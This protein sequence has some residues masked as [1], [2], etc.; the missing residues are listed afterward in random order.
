[1][2]HFVQKCN[3]LMRQDRVMDVQEHF[4]LLK[5]GMLKTIYVH[6]MPTVHITLQKSTLL[7]EFRTKFRCPEV[8]ILFWK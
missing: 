2:I 7:L 4:E 6:L 5:A 3:I 1:M 8:I